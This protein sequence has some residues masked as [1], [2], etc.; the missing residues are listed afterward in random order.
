M[1][2][3]VQGFALPTI[4]ITSLV[5]LMVL[6]TAVSSTVAIRNALNDQQYTQLAELA[7]EAGTVYAK[8][9]LAQNNNGVTWSDEKP[10]RPNTDCSG[11]VQ[12]GLSAYVLE[13][14]NLRTYFVVDKPIIG[15]SNLPVSM[16]GKGYTEM[17]RTSNGIAWR[18][19][20]GNIAVALSQTVDGTP[21]GTSI[22]GYWTTPPDGYLL[23]DGSA[24]SRTTY[25][26][27]FNIIGTTFGA[28]DGSTT[29]NLPDSRGRVTVNKSSD[30]EFNTIG[31]KPGSKTE[32]ISI[33]QMPSHTHIQNSH[34][35]TQNAHN[36]TQNAHSH[37]V[38]PIYRIGGQTVGVNGTAIA[39]SGAYSG[40]PN[41][42]AYSA[43]PAVASYQ[44][45]A[46][47]QATTVTNQ[48]T[49]ATNQNTGSGGSHN[50]IQPSIVKMFAI[51]Y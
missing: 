25:A 19:W 14:D 21:V 10:L 47:N 30:T 36:H 5:F 44:T 20:G 18:V 7:G 17:L 23:E 43:M 34:N 45:R 26:N 3:K 38:Q 51:K 50:N 35:H 41:P 1:K 24:V 32:A 15:T 49:T 29:F 42:G 33:A 11:N 9:C 28:G 4:L 46:V 6:V 37:T 13:Q 8:A 27:L 40:L 22:E 2:I 31:E 12:P 39:G 48:A 16:V